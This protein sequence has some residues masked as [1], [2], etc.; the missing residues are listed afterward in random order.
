M[1]ATSCGDSFASAVIE[2][3]PEAE[4]F[5]RNADNAVAATMLVDGELTAAIAEM[6]VVG[7]EM[8]G[9]RPAE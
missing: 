6:L 1:R 2:S 7:S 9:R 8:R 3:D 5:F 4:S